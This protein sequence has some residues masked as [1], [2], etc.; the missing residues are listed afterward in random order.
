MS[1]REG[2][3]NKSKDNCYHCNELGHHAKDCPQ[4]GEGGKK[5]GTDIFNPRIIRLEEDV[6][7]FSVRDG[8]EFINVSLNKLEYID[9]I[10]VLGVRHSAKRFN[11][12]LSNFYLDTCSMNHTMFVVEL[13]SRVHTA[14]V[15][16]C[17]HCNAGVST[18]RK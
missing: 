18:T 3:C 14:G 12:S 1:S 5:D 11:C 8:P 2:P 10:V 6:M 7:S 16:L 15:T 4:L 9:D 13:L 17:Q